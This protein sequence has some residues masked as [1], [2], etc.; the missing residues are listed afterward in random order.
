MYKGHFQ[1]TS[2]GFVLCLHLEDREFPMW[3]NFRIHKPPQLLAPSYA[4]ACLKQKH[5]LA[6]LSKSPLI[7]HLLGR[8]LLQTLMRKTL[9]QKCDVGIITGC[10]VNSHLFGYLFLTWWGSG[11]ICHLL[12]T[13]KLWILTPTFMIRNL[14]KFA[15]SV[16]VLVLP[17][18]NTAK[19]E[20][21]ISAFHVFCSWQARGMGA[22]SSVLSMFFIGWFLAEFCHSHNLRTEGLFCSFWRTSGS[23]QWKGQ[24]ISGISV[25]AFFFINVSF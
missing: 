25:I 2:F 21:S 13:M 6:S 9:A 3:G 11:M 19:F 5:E 14:S 4:K 20:Q 18:M 16:Q 24:A 23:W 22:L 1:I 15:N 7:H 10:P 8:E 17:Q 12:L